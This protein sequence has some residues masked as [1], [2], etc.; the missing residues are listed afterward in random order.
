MND[1]SAK[2]KLNFCIRTTRRRRTV[3][4]ARTVGPTKQFFNH[5]IGHF[6]VGIRRSHRW[7]SPELNCAAFS[8]QRFRVIWWSCK[9]SLLFN[10]ILFVVDVAQQD[11]ILIPWM[12]SQVTMDA[13]LI[14]LLNGLFRTIDSP[15]FVVWWETRRDT[16]VAGLFTLWVW[17]C[18]R[19]WSRFGQAN[20]IQMPLDEHKTTQLVE[21]LRRSFLL[22]F[23]IFRYV[24]L[25]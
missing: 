13:P 14:S 20:G 24:S 11:L 19:G 6:L 18:I 3:Q 23:A 9:D 4:L 7:I 5:H 25:K 2:H 22:V 16:H 1:F 17:N 10:Y 12:H 21:I 15:F 8:K